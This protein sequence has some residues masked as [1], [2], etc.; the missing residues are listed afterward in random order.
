M[1]NRLGGIGSDIRGGALPL[2]FLTKFRLGG[3]QAMWRAIL[4]IPQC[5]LWLAIYL[6]SDHRLVF[7]PTN[8]NFEKSPG[9]R[10]QDRGRR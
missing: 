10:E 7:H 3:C 1:S 6:S 2:V 9:S 4:R 8:I 5:A